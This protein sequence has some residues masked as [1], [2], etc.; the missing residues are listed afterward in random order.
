MINLSTKT[1]TPQKV[2]LTAT[3]LG[4]NYG[5]KVALQD[6]NLQIH[7]GE[8]VA[9]VGMSGGGKSTLLRLIAGLEA[10]TEGAIDFGNVAPV[11]RVMFQNDRLL[12]WLSVFENVTFHRREPQM[13]ARA[14]EMLRL[15][16]LA[17]FANEYPEQL[18]GGQKQRV[19]LARALM[20][21]P[22]PLLL[23]EPL[24]ALDALTRRKMQELILDVCHKQQ[25]TTILVT[26][27][28]EEAAR[29]AD[30]IVVIKNGTNL[31]EESGFDRHDPA[32]VGV[33]AEKVLH[34]IIDEE[35]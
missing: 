22:Q 19:A 10:N 2:M 12:P 3:H 26:H 21:E 8:F 27:D 16:G 9:L 28:V 34:D 23:D 15:V 7:Q 14:K 11:I 33:V 5:R 18:S 31:Y 17:D 20:A 29:M 25:L 32:A 1:E 35:G 30:R 13:R 24:G 4:K 6:V